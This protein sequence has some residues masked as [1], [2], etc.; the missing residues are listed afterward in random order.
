MGAREDRGGFGVEACRAK[1]PPVN[2]QS[3]SPS[4]RQAW[5]RRRRDGASAHTSC[6]FTEDLVT[7]QLFMTPADTPGKLFLD[8][9]YRDEAEGRK[10]A[11]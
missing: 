7:E 3:A 8:Y 10:S 9:I 5:I 2:R 11:S 4:F 1:P 6:P